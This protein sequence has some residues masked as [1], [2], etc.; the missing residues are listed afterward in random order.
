MSGGVLSK[1][2][3][4]RFLSLSCL[5]VASQE[6]GKKVEPWSWEVE[7]LNKVRRLLSNVVLLIADYRLFLCPPFA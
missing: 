3:G 5:Y 7:W 4:H 2:A 1:F 6:L